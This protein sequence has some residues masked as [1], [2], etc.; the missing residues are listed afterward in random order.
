MFPEVDFDLSVDERRTVIQRHVDDD[1]DS[2]KQLWDG[3]D[4]LLEHVTK[5]VADQV[6]GELY[7]EI[8]LRVGFFPQLGFMTAVPVGGWKGH[9]RSDISDDEWEPIF[10]AD[11]QT[12]YKNQ[13]MRELDEHFGDI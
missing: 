2:L 3:L 8:E 12:F 7:T 5:A 10:G 9:S 13:Q 4:D 6:Y 1:L 11:C